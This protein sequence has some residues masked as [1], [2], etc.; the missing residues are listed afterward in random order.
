MRADVA[1]ESD[2]LRRVSSLRRDVTT[3][4]LASHV[5][6]SLLDAGFATIGDLVGATPS[7][8]ARQTG[9]TQDEALEALQHGGSAS[10]GVRGSVWKGGATADV[11]F[12]RERRRRRVVTFC[13][14]LDGMLGGGVAPCEIT[15][16]CGVPGIGKTQLGMQLAV[17]VQIPQ[18]FGGVAGQAVYIDTEGS[19]MAERAEEIADA[20]LEHLRRIATSSQDADLV[21]MAG[22]LDVERVLA[23]IHYFRVHDSTQQIALVHVL[24]EFL[25]AH[26]EVRVVIVDSVAF[27]FRQDFTDMAK[28]TRILAGMMQGLM[29]LANDREVAVVVMNQVTT[30]IQAGGEARLV[31]ALGDSFAHA[32]TNRVLL[33][34]QECRRHAHLYKSPYLPSRTVAYE[35]TSQG[36]RGVGMST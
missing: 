18:A 13:P 27:H 26:P 11:I 31:P 5:R 16:F 3:L 6:Q 25:R 1:S 17:D 22:R 2:A 15:E 20:C 36:V 23:N 10:S 32:S 14:E 33:F 30:K 34:W 35:L 29:N 28:R 21:R 9:I 12:R 24:P 19:F 7:L 8:L 4:P